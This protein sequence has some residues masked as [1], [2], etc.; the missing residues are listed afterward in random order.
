MTF[1]AKDTKSVQKNN[2]KSLEQQTKGFIN[3][4][5]QINSYKKKRKMA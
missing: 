4:K 1:K 5:N 2:S 3:L